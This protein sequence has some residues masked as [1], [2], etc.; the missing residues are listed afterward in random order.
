[1]NDTGSLWRLGACSYCPLSDFVGTSCEEAAELESLAHR[2]DGL[3]KCRLGVEVLEFLGSLLIGHD[4]NALLELHRDGNDWVARGVSLD[5]F[6][7]LGK[8]LVL[9]ADVVL[10]AQVDKVY[11]RLSG[12]KEKRVD[13]LDLTNR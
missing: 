11:N 10:L 5:P 2:L 7:N 4:S 6:S 3:G 12:E 8:M 1:M 9:L 13:V